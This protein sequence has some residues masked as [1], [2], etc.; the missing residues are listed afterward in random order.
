M[1]VA[2][3]LSRLAELVLLLVGF[4]TAARAY[5]GWRKERQ[6]VHEEDPDRKDRLTEEART[7]YLLATL[8]HPLTLVLL[9]LAFG[10]KLVLLL[11][12]GARTLGL[13]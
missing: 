4:V 1:T 3:L 6:A 8:R 5:Q 12:D 7:L 11:F 10:V 13:F 2:D 9:M